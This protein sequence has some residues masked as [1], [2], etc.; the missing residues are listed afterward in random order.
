[1]RSVVRQ[2]EERPWTTLA[3][4]TAVTAALYL[5]LLWLGP[6]YALSAPQKERPIPLVIGLYAAAFVPYWL[7]WW[8]AVRTPYDRRL[9]WWLLGSSLLW[10]A[11]LL[12][13]PPFQ[14][15]DIYRYLWDGKAVSLGVDPYR[16]PPAD[17][18]A[19]IDD[20]RQGR[21]V[22]DG[23]LTELV[24]AATGGGGAYEEIVRTIHYGEYPS[25]YPPVS[26]AVFAASALTSP[27]DT[28]LGHLTWLKVWLT[29]FDFATL[30][31]V[32]GLLR[33]A[34]LPIGHA[35]AYG[36]CPLVMK[37]I[38]GSGHLDSIA[39]FFAVLSVY[40]AVVGLVPRSDA[41]KQPDEERGTHWPCLIGSA[42]ALG[43][44]VGAKLFPVVLAPLLVI[45]WMRRLGIMPA[46]AGAGVI[47][48]T[49]SLSLAPMFSGGES[50]AP[51][52]TTA[53]AAPNSADG[54]L[55]APPPPLTAGRLS[56]TDKTAGLAAFLSQWE[57]NDLIFAVVLENLRPQADVPAARKPWFVAT[58]DAFSQ[59]V[60]DA[61][62][63]VAAAW[64]PAA[65]DWSDG[66]ASF[67]LA[68]AISA[69]AFGLV[70]L[71][72]AWRAATTDQPAAVALP[73]AAFLTL[74]WFWLLAP[75]QNPWYWC[76]ALPL[77]P[78]ARTR[79]WGLLAALALLYYTRFW[80]EYHHPNPPVFG[81]RYDGPFFFYFVIAWI[82]F[83]PW[84][85]LLASESAWRWRR[86]RVEGAAA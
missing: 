40:A 77:L 14:E 64:L 48:V 85:L 19:A 86:V 71:L 28:A 49:A 68:R 11:I 82:E 65:A 30:L 47:V 54:A 62:R 81:T 10:R 45:V 59:R 55:P 15:I 13:T 74:A 60:I 80:F 73:R 66:Q 29:G 1:M 35:V 7:A 44:G 76:W 69:A 63:S 38:A 37:E 20:A 79:A 51:A 83:A 9:V 72:L 8:L 5:A 56:A 39:T 70:A 16:Y 23:Q 17:V 12:P 4:L 46:L 43:L 58:S 84:L 52:V 33:R 26:Q 50:A 3:W 22:A 67:F 2:F 18:V 34:Q 61:W 41:G 32:V 25:P 6:Q 21:A 75:T 24:A 27:F 42:S 57:M 78:F 53:E 36:W 31:V